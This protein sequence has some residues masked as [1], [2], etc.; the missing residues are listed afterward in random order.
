[1]S[2]IEPE[3]GVERSQAD[4]LRIIHVQ[5]L[6]RRATG[7]RQADDLEGRINRPLKVIV[8]CQ[9]TGMKQ[10][11]DFTSRCVQAVEMI[12]LVDVTDRAGESQ[13]LQRAEAATTYRVDVIQFEST[14]LE[15]TGQQAVFASFARPFNNSM[16]K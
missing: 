4:H 2:A 1:M 14:D 3:F 16:T 5:A 9:L 12:Q 13:V 6:D 15:P 10:R 11:R 8:P 7:R